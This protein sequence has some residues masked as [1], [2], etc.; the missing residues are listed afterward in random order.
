MYYKLVKIVFPSVIAQAESEE[1]REI[2]IYGLVSLV[3]IAVTLFALLLIGYISGNLLGTIIYLIGLYCIR[4][5]AGGYHANT[6]EACLMSSI[7]IYSSIVVI[8][9]YVTLKA[10]LILVILAAICYLSVLAMGPI[11]NGK[12]EFSYEEIRNV[13][14]KIRI[15]LALELVVT[16]VLFQFNYELYKFAIY[17]ILSEGMV[18]IMGKIKYWE[19]NKK[20]VLKGIKDLSENAAVHNAGL[21]CSFWLYEHEMPKALKKKFEK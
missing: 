4:V 13:K 10:N 6:Q 7:I 21:P 17:A 11:L 3:S 14:K 20:N 16:I 9:S 19:L 18:L 5:L 2:V 12:R 15:V 1:E 8:N